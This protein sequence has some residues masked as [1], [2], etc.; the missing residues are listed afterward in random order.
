MKPIARL[1]TLFTL[2]VTFCVLSA[3]AQ[4]VVNCDT[5]CGGA[6][7]TTGAGSIPFRTA[8]N[9][10]RGLGSVAQPSVGPL[11]GV[12]A[13][14][15][16]TVQGSQ[17]FTYSVPLFSV[18]GRNGLDVN[19]TLYYNSFIWTVMG[20][21]IVLN[22]DHDNPSPGFRL[23][24]GY[25]E[26]SPDSGSGVLVDATG[27]KHPLSAGSAGGGYITTDSTYIQAQIMSPPG[28]VLVAKFKNG[29]TVTYN[30]AQPSGALLFRP[31]QFKDTNGNFFSIFYQDDSSLRLSEVIDDVG[32][33]IFFNYDTATPTQLNS[34]TEVSAGN[35]PVRTYTFSWAQ[36]YPLY[37]AFTEKTGSLVNADGSNP[38][39][40]NVLTGVTRPDGTK[41]AFGYADWGL[42][43]Q[44]SELSSNGTPRYSTGF[45]WPIAGNGF[46]SANPTYT[47]QTI[48]DGVNTGVWNY[49]VQKNKANVVTNFSV[50]DPTG[51]TKTTIFSAS[52]DSLDGVPL[53]QL[54]CSS[55]PCTTSSTNIL[56]AT[57]MKWALDVSGANARLAS[58][59]TIQQDGVT[60]NQVQFNAYDSGG[61]VTDLLQYDFGAGAP[62]P[63]LKETVTTFAAVANNI[64]NRPTRVVVKD[65]KGTIVSRADM[66]YDEVPV[67]DFSVNSAGHDPAYTSAI[68]A[69]GNLTTL[70][71]Y[72]N[73]AAGSVGIRTKFSYDATGNA[74]TSQ[75]GSGPQ[76]RQS[77]STATWYAF[78]DSVSVGPVSSALT[79]SFVYD[80]DGNVLS[81]TDPN[82]QNAT[83]TYDSSGRLLTTTS[84]DLSTVSFSYDDASANPAIRQ[85]STANRM[86]T[87]QVTDGL[88]RIINNQILNGTAVVGTV[89]R[90]NDILGRPMQ[91]SN[92][93]GPADAPNYTTY[94]YDALGRITQIVPPAVGSAVQNAYQTNYSGNAITTT[95]PAGLQRKRY[96]DALGRLA[97]VDEPGS[98]GGAAAT[99][100]VSISGTDLSVASNSAGNGA[101]AGTAKIVLAATAACSSTITDRCNTKVV[102]QA[103]AQASV[104]VTIGGQDGTTQTCSVI[105]GNTRCTIPVP[106]SGKFTLQ[107][108]VAGTAIS[109]TA[110]YNGTTNTSPQAVAQALAQ[111]LQGN[112]V[113]Q[114]SY[115]AGS[116][117]LTLTTV[118]TGNAMNASMVTASINSD[119]VAAMNAGGNQ[120]CALGWNLILSGPGLTQPAPTQSATSGNFTGGLDQILTTKYDTGTIKAGFTVNGTLISEQVPYGQTDTAATLAQALFNKFSQDTNATPYVNAGCTNATCSDGILNL[121]TIAT[122]SGTNYPLTLATSTNSAYFTSG[123]TS[124]TATSP[125]SSF[126]PGQSGLLFD[127]GTVTAQLL[128]FTAGNAPTETV[129]YGQ[130]ST[131]AGIA[132]SL[133]AK[134]SGDPLW[135][136][137]SAGVPA[138]SA[139]ITFTA[140]TKGTDANSYSV[141]I[142]GSSNL[143]SFFP[144]PSFP[145]A[146]S[147]TPVT[148]TLSGGAQYTPSFD[149]SVVLTTT[150][151]YDPMGNLLQVNQGQQVRTYTYDGL[152]ELLT[153]TIPETGYNV[154]SFT[155]TDFGA[156]ATKI[157]PRVL[158]GTSTPITTTYSYD[159]LARLS[160]ITY[161]DGTPEV[162]FSFGAPGAPNNGGGRLI[163][164]SDGTG[165]KSY[166]YDPMGR[167]SQVTQIVAGVPYSINYDYNSAGE[168]RRLT[169]PSGRVV[170][171]KY[172]PMGRFAEVDNNG[173]AVYS[174]TSYNAAGQILG[175]S[176]G[177]GMIGSYGYNPQLQLASIQYGSSS[178]AI[179]NLAYGYGGASD[180][181]QIQ[182]ITDGVVPARSTQYAYDELGRLKIAQTSDQTSTNTWK[183]EFTYDRYGNRLSQV[184]V[185]GTALQPLNE[186]LVD[187]NTNHLVAGGQAYDAAG[188]MTSDGVHSYTYDAEGKITH[189]DGTANTFGYDGDGFR[190]N[191]NGIIHIASQG[192]VIA[193]YITGAAASV[194]NIEY[195]YASGQRVAEIGSGAVTYDY[196]DHLSSVRSRADSTA[197]PIRT[198]GHFPFGEPSYETGPQYKWKFTTY[199]RDPDSEGGLD[200]ANARFYSSRVG[201]FMSRDPLTGYQGAPQSLNRYLY[202]QN[203]PINFSDPTGMGPY[204]VIYKCY[205]KAD[206]S[207]DHCDIA[208]LLQEVEVPADP[209]QISA[210][211]A[212]QGTHLPLQDGP[213]GRHG[214]GFNTKC[215]GGT[216]ETIVNIADAVSGAAAAEKLVHG[217]ASRASSNAAELAS[218][219]GKAGGIPAE[220][221]SLTAAGTASEAVGIL[222]ATKTFA[223]VAGVVGK[224]S[225]WTLV[226]AG[227][228]SFGARLYCYLSH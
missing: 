9:A 96:F 57:Q 141:R 150:Y 13:K 204:D 123:S 212:G 77:L 163:S 187:P 80:A 16:V 119:C 180:N 46:L 58:I 196:V 71:E 181:G 201:R 146:G 83:L 98:L 125:N 10:T 193:E 213:E 36:S 203:D 172:D 170:D 19:L 86:V 50:S 21:S 113:V 192:Q 167:I 18:Q 110:T 97:R 112:S 51:K 135:G 184:P 118:A 29:L 122:G 2:A 32:R 23:D 103:A 178:G 62:G 188:N 85:S 60:Q 214:G 92:P 130:G 175:M 207:L 61:N 157:N 26:F 189:V 124:F 159:P 82:G 105:H 94:S 104:T 197:T 173:S 66:S 31:A 205:Y 20:N 28:T 93:F 228:I 137:V 27:A 127:N 191:K 154:T 56:G 221:V 217:L 109:S 227:G 75:R 47:E 22:A 128:G 153:S 43:S 63:L 156:V 169:Y 14:V 87:R 162:K 55:S 106:D 139:S 35:V 134:I 174:A 6:E 215:L 88:G 117:S 24:F 211:A 202:V 90:T 99:G 40:I 194:P 126:V 161:N 179:L 155:Y 149:P 129:N 158:P 116:A 165:S 223:S 73:A 171:E 37:I 225:G 147:S 102:Q 114:A 54:V 76:M 108:N 78:P 182:T 222:N 3:S 120:V 39:R 12:G 15:P 5:S 38:S 42:V 177:N 30:A 72:A 143:S 208:P 49:A 69:R 206:G 91:V 11:P 59:T 89:T 160:D 70:I 121:T 33:K 41:V 168:L 95:D 132:A 144:N 209:S 107:M 7:P 220:E 216:A 25:I 142:S 198:S 226:A 224:L 166:Q 101:T 8:A 67:T 219:L 48:F 68:V 199:E 151:N 79:T 200:Y 152:G 111:N 210:I 131:A 84:P 1:L 138:G 4:V 185:G 186:V 136:A 81:K 148:A 218:Q 44:V 164:T 34:V 140:A 176:Y 133:V 17:S 52:G 65:G 53:Q 115:T 64:L 183:L 195:I 145:S 45:N 74:I 190:V 100:S